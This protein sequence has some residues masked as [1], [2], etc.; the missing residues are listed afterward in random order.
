M[1]NRA[2]YVL[3]L[4]YLL[5]VGFILYINGVFDGNISSMS[6]IWINVGF[7]AVIGVLFLISFHSFRKLNRCTDALEIAADKLKREYKEKGECLWGIY[8]EKET[9]FG[10]A[11]LDDAFARYQKRLRGYETRSGLSKTCDLEEYINEDLLDSVGMSF[12]NSAIPGTLTGLGILGTFLGLSLGLGSFSGNDIYTIS[13]NVGVLLGGMKVA[14]HTSVYGIFF[15]L[16]FN[17]LYRMVVSEAYGKLSVFLG[18]FREYAMPQAGADM[19]AK[20][21]LIYQANMANSLKDMTNLLKGNLQDQMK[22]VERM[23]R[24]FEEQLAENMGADFSRL[25]EALD[26]SAQA[27]SLAASNFRSLEETARNLLETNSAMQREMEMNRERQ[28]AFARELK[29]QKNKL[30]DTCRT[31]DEEISSQLY[32]YSQMRNL[33]EE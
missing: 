2:Y 18:A 15:S 33:D 12:Y 23:V 8:R 27:Q 11:V 20:A 10:N 32:T 22:G 21:L 3:Y 24:H 26:R 7:L 19:D 28:E 4:L 17:F 30:D 31:L 9:V 13:D 25:G 29:E 6:N 16:V 5:M 14:F 1:K